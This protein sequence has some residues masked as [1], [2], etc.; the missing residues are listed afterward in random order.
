MIGV[1]KA[2]RGPRGCPLA[3]APRHLQ[4]YF[5]ERVLVASWYPESDYRDLLL[6]LGQTLGARADASIWRTLGVWGAER[7][8]QGIYSAM[9]RPGDPAWTLRSLPKGW[10]QFHDSGRVTLEEVGAGHARL[11]LRDYPVMC[12]PLAEVNSGYLEGLLKLSGARTVK[13]ELQ[14]HDPSSARWRLY[15]TSGSA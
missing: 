15:W 4:P 1:V 11:T 10:A 3:Q 12:L 7:D 13:V 9:L 8:L 5:K 14:E 2:L 6:L